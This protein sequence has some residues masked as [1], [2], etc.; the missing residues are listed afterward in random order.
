MQ[1]CSA[2]LALK[3]N[4][5]IA[6][7]TGVNMICW[8]L[9]GL[10]LYW[11]AVYTRRAWLRCVVHGNAFSCPNLRFVPLE[12]W[13]S[14]LTAP[15]VV[16]CFAKVHYCDGHVD[17]LDTSDEQG[18]GTFICTSP[19]G[20]SMFL[21]FLALPSQPCFPN[22]AFLA[23]FFQPCLPSHALLALLFQPCLPSPAFPALPS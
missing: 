5:N 8:W 16:S 6:L 1:S 13:M 19:H 12:G 21:A 15:G 3:F 22:T 11:T 18:C 9:M 20:C 4:E 10:S 23:L 7:L 17:C 2:C 14:C